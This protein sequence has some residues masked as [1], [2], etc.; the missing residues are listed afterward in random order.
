MQPG[1]DEILAEKAY[2]KAKE[3][4]KITG[5]RS[6][7]LEEDILKNHRYA[8]WYAHE[9][10]QGFWP[11]AEP[12][13]L[14]GAQA[15]YWYAEK[16]IKGRWP[17]AEKRFLINPSSTDDY[18][19]MDYYAINI[20]KGRWIEAEQFIISFGKYP[21]EKRY[22]QLLREKNYTEKEKL[23]WI[24]NEGY[25]DNLLY[26][27]SNIGT[28]KSIQELIIQNRPDLIQSIG[29]LDPEIREKYNHEWNLVSIP[30]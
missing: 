4:F 12:I 5:Q 8:F 14:T 24:A 6:P 10:I 16:I 13:I 11:E 27:F 21:A 30:I 18:Y 15:R 1:P 2:R 26:I 19:F 28:T 3:N 29:E 17:E 25:T 22:F 23:Q 20:I 7:E 9:I